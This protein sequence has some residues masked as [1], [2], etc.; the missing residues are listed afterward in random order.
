MIYD[1]ELHGRTPV[2]VLLDMLR[3]YLPG[4][5]FSGVAMP[6]RRGRPARHRA[7]PSN[8]HEGPVNERREEPGPERGGGA[9]PHSEPETQPTASREADPVLARCYAE[10]GVPYGADFPEVRRAWR[11][12][13]RTH[14]P[15]VQGDDAERQRIGTEHVKRF[16]RAFE[17]IGRR[18]REGQGGRIHA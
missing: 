12:L 1:G 16:N 11:R 15:D 8:R 7:R 14:H 10:L 9:P 5:D 2:E 4:I 3:A 17:E 6:R 13:M 18:L